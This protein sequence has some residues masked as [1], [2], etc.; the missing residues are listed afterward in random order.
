[1]WKIDRTSGTIFRIADTLHARETAGGDAGMRFRIPV[2]IF[3][4]LLVSTEAAA[5]STCGEE[6][7]RR[8]VPAEHSESDHAG[9]GKSL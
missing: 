9:S 1:M 6:R 4:D 3:V 7:Q 5:R 8:P 2:E